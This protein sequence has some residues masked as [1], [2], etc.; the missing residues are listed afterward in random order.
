MKIID[1]KNLILLLFVILLALFVRIIYL[2]RI[3]TGLSDDELLYALQSRAF[4]YTGK[5]LTDQWSP[6]S[7]D[8]PPSNVIA[9][10]ARIPYIL[11][12]PYFSFVDFSLLTIRFPYAFIASLFTIVIYLL[13]SGLFS[14]KAGIIASFIYALNPWSIYFSRTAYEAPIALYFAYSA[15]AYLLFAKSINILFV[16]PLYFLSFYSYMGTNIIL[17]V[18]MLAICIYAWHKNKNKYGYEYAIVIGFTILLSVIY[19]L[20]LPNDLGGSRIGEL[21]NPFT[22]DVSKYVD[23]YRRLSISTPYMQYFTNRF[24]SIFDI[25]INQYIGLFSPDFLFL[26]GDSAARYSLWMHGIFYI[27]DPILLLIGLMLLFRKYF[28]QSIL[29]I[30]IILISPIPSAIH[31][32]D[33]QYVLRSSFMYPVIILLVGLGLYQLFNFIKNI[34]YLIFIIYIFLYINFFYIYTYQNPIYNYESFGISGRIFSKYAKLASDKGYKIQMI[35]N[36][37]NKELFRQYLFFNNRYNYLTYQNIAFQLTKDVIVFDNI[38]FISCD[39][40]DNNPEII[41]IIPFNHSCIKKTNSEKY[42]SLTD[43]PKNEPIYQIFNDKICD[44]YNIKTYMEDIKITDLK[45]EDLPQQRFCE[46]YFTRDAGYNDINN[47][48]SKN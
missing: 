28:S 36:G 47:K 29:L 18:F 37:P 45:I 24:K 11:L 5:D 44:K 31:F 41:S 8:K 3:P 16:I 48:I 6:I 34:T 43:F 26:K 33:T 14:K 39:D 17:P 4:F 13:G 21:L 19:I 2:D 30:I 40:F 12:S 46:K 23:T 38:K 32:G 35:S 27:I 15:F 42:L 1:K 22:V 25:F 20:H 7:M 9:P 10:Y